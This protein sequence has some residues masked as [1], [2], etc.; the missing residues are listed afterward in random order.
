[1]LSGIARRR[2]FEAPIQ[3]ES[4]NRIPIDPVPN[5]SAI[6]RQTGQLDP[7][8]RRARHRSEPN[9]SKRRI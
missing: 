1:V 5:A 9:F 4:A 6:E 7:S 3:A 2:L 8:K